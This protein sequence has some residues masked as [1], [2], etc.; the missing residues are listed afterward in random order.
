MIQHSER[1]IFAAHLS[2]SQTDNF[3]CRDLFALGKL[4]CAETAISAGFQPQIIQKE[5]RRIV[6]L[7]PIRHIS[8]RGNLHLYILIYSLPVSQEALPFD[9]GSHASNYWFCF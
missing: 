7:S 8:K 6:N 9:L 4:T 2:I 5:L 1:S 3:F